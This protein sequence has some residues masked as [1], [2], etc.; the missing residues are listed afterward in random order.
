M[1]TKRNSQRLR[2]KHNRLKRN[3]LY[4]FGRV[5]IAAE[6]HP[7]AEPK[8]DATHPLRPLFEPH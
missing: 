4:E 7:Q 2:L 6:Q 8:L 3:K 5:K 1:R